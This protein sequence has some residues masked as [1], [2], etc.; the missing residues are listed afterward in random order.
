MAEKEVLLTKEQLKLESLGSGF[1]VA[2]SGSGRKGPTSCARCKRRL[3]NPHSIARSLGPVCYKASGG[4]AFDKDMQASE[5]EWERR[6]DDLRKGGEWDFGMWDYVV[7]PR[8]PGDLPFVL[9]HTLRV[10]VRFQDGKFEAYGYV[11]SPLDIPEEERE[12]VFYRGDDIRACWAAAIAAG[13][14]SNAAAYRAEREIARQ[15]KA[16][17]RGGGRRVR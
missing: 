4:G 7:Q 13:P 9:H 3:T 15:W 5:A 8:Q 17:L 2:D 1:M 10:S 6:A 14:E 12:I 11:C 16:Q